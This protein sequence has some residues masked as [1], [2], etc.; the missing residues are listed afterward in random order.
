MGGVPFQCEFS[1]LSNYVSAKNF[2][3]NG[4]LSL[5]P[6]PVPEAGKLEIFQDTSREGEGCLM[7]TLLGDDF[8]Y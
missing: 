2:A 4:Q 1:I 6:L 8:F 5:R 7:S 3:Y